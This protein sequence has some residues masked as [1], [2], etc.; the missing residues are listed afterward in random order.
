MSRATLSVTVRVEAPVEAVWAA[1]TDWAGQS[2]WILGTEVSVRSGDGRSVGSRI[3]AFTGVS[4]LGVLDTMT[5]TAWEPP[6]RVEVLH[7]GKLLRGP[8]AIEV[9]AAG[10]G[11]VL[12]WSE[13]LELPFGVLGRLGWRAG[14]PA[15]RWGFERSLRRLARS[16][17]RAGV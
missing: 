1:V 4:R 13:D 3:D 15:V 2:E 16:L 11:S 10:G 17:E 5:I 7:D 12:T 6:H 14:R 8:G 9:R